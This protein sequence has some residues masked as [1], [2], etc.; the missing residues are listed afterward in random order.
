MA[1]PRVVN[2]QNRACLEHFALSVA[3]VLS[4]RLTLILPFDWPGTGGLQEPPPHVM[5]PEFDGSFVQAL[6]QLT[7]ASTVLIACTFIEPSEERIVKNIVAAVQNNSIPIFVLQVLPEEISSQEMSDD[8]MRRH[9][10]MLDTGCDDVIIDP[11]AESLGSEVE[12]ARANWRLNVERMQELHQLES[13]QENILFSIIPSIMVPE[14]PQVDAQLEEKIG[15]VG[16]YTMLKRLHAGDRAVVQ[17]VSKTRKARV[18][19]CVDKSKLLTPLDVEEVVLEYRIMHTSLKHPNIARC[20]E[21]LHGLSCIYLVFNNAGDTNLHDALLAEA[22][23][24]FDLEIAIACFTQVATGVAFMHSKKVSHRFLSLTHVVVSFENT[25]RENLHCS[26]VD[27]HLGTVGPPGRL[28]RRQCGSFPFMAPEVA[29]GAHYIPHLTDLWNLGII[30]LEAAGGLGSYC[31]GALG[32]QFQRVLHGQA[33]VVVNRR[34]MLA[35][36]AQA[37]EFFSQAGNHEK[38]LAVQ[39]GVASPIVVSVL[40]RLIERRPAERAS[41]REILELVGSHGV[42]EREELQLTRA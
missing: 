3:A 28:H 18:I 41:A 17:A 9:D 19:K 2:L 1:L 21:A 34:I 13:Q 37:A 35:A 8:T 7:N 14:F 31:I 26:I 42:P 10:L 30:L 12:I 15:S 20:V 23:Q 40:E 11:T 38:A 36:I 39:G 4:E 16:Q 6:S 24:R 33:G 29:E 27:F 25:H 22:G 5:T 32:L